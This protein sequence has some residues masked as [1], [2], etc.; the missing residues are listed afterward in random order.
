[1]IAEILG[2][3]ADTV[4]EHVAAACAKL[5]VRTRLQAAVEACMLGL[6]D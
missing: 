1:M 6:I 3:S 5:G 4:E 2:L